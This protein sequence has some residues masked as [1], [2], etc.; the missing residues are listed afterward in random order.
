MDCNPKDFVVAVR[1]YRERLTDDPYRPT[2]HFAVPD[3]KGLPGDPNG[4]FFADGVYHLMYLYHNAETDGFHWG[5]VSSVDLLHWRHHPDALT[6][7]EGDKGC[8]SGGAFLDEDKTAY[9]TFWQ[10]PAKDG[11]NNGGIGIAYARPPYEK[12]KRMERLAVESTEW[13][14]K[15]EV[16]DGETLHLGCAD[17]SNIWR[18]N[19][20]YYMQLGNLLVLNKYGREENS[21]EKYRGGWTELYRSDDLRNWEFLHRFYDKPQPADDLPDDTEDDMCPSFLPLYDAPANGNFTRK[22]LQLFISHNK[23]CQYFVGELKGEKFVPEVHG[24]M[25]RT[26][27]RS[28]FAPEAL[29]D[30]KRRHIMWVWLADNPENDFERYGWTGV[31]SF[32]RTV[33]WQDGMLKMAPAEEIE[34]L[35]INKQTLIPAE[36]GK[37]PVKNGE[38]FRIKAE[39]DMSRCDKAGF[40]VRVDEER[41]EYTEI[42]FDKQRGKLVFDSTHSGTEGIKAKEEAPLLLSENEKLKLDIFVDKSV[43]EVYANDKQAIC[44]R[45]YPTYPENAKGVYVCDDTQP[46]KAECW[47]MAPSMMY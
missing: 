12:W 42:Y 27:Q 35:Q 30:D 37:L 16:I 46:E 22:W 24:R 9:L 10:F 2:Y 19:G 6:T 45:V 32:P 33:W 3:D 5:H 17:P 40:R 21:P 7:F 1:K 26:E 8:Y 20:K 34:R 38:S 41:D 13:G 11:K 23:G 14:I 31:F 44:R 43:V 15:D 36:N 28:Y 4:A 25:S 39:W 29:I 18:A 47:E